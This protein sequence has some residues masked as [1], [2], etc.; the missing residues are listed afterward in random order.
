[1][2]IGTNV[3]HKIYGEGIITDMTIDSS[4]ILNSHIVVHFA[5]SNETKKFQM[6]MFRDEKFFTTD[7]PE[8][9]PYV[10]E[11]ETEADKPKERKIVKYVENL[12]NE[13]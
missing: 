9:I 3:N 2:F 13:F 8:I 5:K 7:D 1:M 10:L 6:R 11:Q 4:N 12:E